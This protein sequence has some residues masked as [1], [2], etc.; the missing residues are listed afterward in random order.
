M[1]E[2]SKE[3]VLE[4]IEHYG[5]DPQ[6]IVA[7]LLDIQVFSGRNY[8]DKKWAVFVSETMNIPLSKIYDIVTFYEMFSLEPR[9]EYVIEICKSPPCYFTYTKDVVRWFEEAAGIKMGETTADGKI[10][11]IFT[12]CVGACDI[13]PAVKIGDAVFGGL[14][15][16][17]VRTLVNRC[18]SGDI[19][20]LVREEL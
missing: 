10:S 3:R 1:Q 2:L 4:I 17:R 11:L 7:I 9:G 6:Q 12:S 14:T 5:G 16:N 15:A 19:K 18:L 8:L 20:P 13:S